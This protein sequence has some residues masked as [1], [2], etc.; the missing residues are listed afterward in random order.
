L[1]GDQEAITALVV[2]ATPTALAAARRITGDTS[3]AEDAAQDAFVKAFRALDRFRPQS[4]FRA[5][6]RAIAIRCAID[7][8]RRRRPESPLPDA[9]AAPGDEEARHED[10]DLL[11]AALAALPRLDR[12]IMIAR[13]VEGV[14]DRVIAE[15]FELSVT[16]VRVRVHRARRRI[17]A[18]FEEERP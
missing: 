17:R 16:A 1:R 9:Q 14:P 13:E 18:R 6:V 5:W 2:S 4:N 7:L 15:R 3:L 11:R 8:V 12:E 10:R